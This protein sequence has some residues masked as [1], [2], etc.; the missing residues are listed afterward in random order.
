[1]RVRLVKPEDPDGTLYSSLT[2]GAEYEVIGIEGDWLRLVDDLG[3]PL[4]YDP[5][6]FLVTD[7][8][9]PGDWVSVVQDGERYAYPPEWRRPGF[10]EDWHDGVPEVRRQFSEE[11]ARRSSHPSN[12]V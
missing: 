11:L 9:E 4:L 10:F 1:M 3:E 7:D 5:A 2:L 8:S 6:S 12:R